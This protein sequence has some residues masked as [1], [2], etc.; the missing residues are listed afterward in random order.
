MTT[1]PLSYDI[2]LR[3]LPMP[4]AQPSNRVAYKQTRAKLFGSFG[5][6]Q[7]NKQLMDYISEQTNQLACLISLFESIY[8]GTYSGGE[9]VVTMLYVKLNEWYSSH[10][11]GS[12][13]KAS[14]SEPIYGAAAQDQRL[15]RSSDWLRQ[16]VKVSRANATL[17]P[18]RL[19][20]R[21][22]LPTRL[23][24][25]YTTTSKASDIGISSTL[26]IKPDNLTKI[27]AQSGLE[28]ICLSRHTPSGFLVT[29]KRLPGYRPILPLQQPWK[30]WI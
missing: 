19:L 9:V 21:F 10:L 22:I 5:V 15:P 6:F 1:Q 24:F 29:K 23:L 17:R 7:A 2:P 16:R 11:L 27:H 26:I 3:D 8:R 4:S 30:L 20:Y 25:T 18:L 12:G 28:T 14:Q 13:L